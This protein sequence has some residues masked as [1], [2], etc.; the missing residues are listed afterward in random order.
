MRK[1]IVCV[2]SSSCFLCL[3]CERGKKFQPKSLTCAYN[4][5]HTLTHHTHTHTHSTK[6]ERKC[7]TTTRFLQRILFWDSKTWREK[8]DFFEETIFK[9]EALSLRLDDSFVC[10]VCPSESSRCVIIIWCV[11]C[12]WC[13]ERTGEGRGNDVSQVESYGGTYLSIRIRT[14]SNLQ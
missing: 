14:H 6:T 3:M 11:T 1:G 5:K 7:C 4:N 12:W 9:D 13:G 2:F 8:I 10:K